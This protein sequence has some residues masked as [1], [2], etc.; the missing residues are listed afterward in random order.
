MRS[1]PDHRSGSVPVYDF[2]DEGERLQSPR[3]KFLQQ[4][5]FGEAMQVTF[6]TPPRARL[7]DALDLRQPRA[8][9]DGRAVADD[10]CAEGLLRVFANDIE[11]S[12]FGPAP[13]G[14]RP[15]S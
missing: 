6:V 4:Q 10:G 3:T 7:P 14:H 15:D 2:G 1:G 5:E 13:P 12:R 9:R 8:H 11:Q